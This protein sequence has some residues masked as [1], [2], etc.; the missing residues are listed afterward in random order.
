M[1]N[2]I[3]QNK[4][5]FTLTLLAAIGLGVFLLPVVLFL[6]LTMMMFIGLNVLIAKV[7][8]GTLTGSGFKK[9]KYAFYKGK[10]EKVIN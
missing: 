4:L 5:S 3:F 8:G 10:I 9:P 1:S 6:W 7:R 2:L